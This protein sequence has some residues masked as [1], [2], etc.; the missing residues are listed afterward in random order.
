MVVKIGGQVCTRD[1]ISAENEITFQSRR[2][3]GLRSLIT[4][5]IA[6]IF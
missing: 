1:Y 5:E 3:G 4:E 2:T 6:A